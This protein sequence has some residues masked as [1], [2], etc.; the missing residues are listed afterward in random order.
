MRRH[1][2][3]RS[4][5]LEAFVDDL[6]MKRRGI[7][8]D[9]HVYLCV[10][11]E[12]DILVIDKI[13]LPTIPLLQ[14]LSSSLIFI[15]FL[16]WKLCTSSIR[17]VAHNTSPRDTNS[18]QTMVVWEVHRCCMAI[19][20]CQGRLR[21]CQDKSTHVR[22]CNCAENRPSTTAVI[23]LGHLPRTSMVPRWRTQQ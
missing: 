14:R 21:D 9:S 7:H 4:D 6:R 11:H 16:V 19:Y 2:E 20:W 5:V 3:T 8:Q 22:C 18:Q 12:L 10:F 23:M 15:T 17:I 13:L 1:L